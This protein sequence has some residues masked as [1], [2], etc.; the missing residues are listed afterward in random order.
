[1]QLLGGE[2]QLAF[3]F[4]EVLSVEMARRLAWRKGQELPSIRGWCL[5]ATERSRRV[6]FRTRADDQGALISSTGLSLP[7]G[8]WTFY[9]QVKGVDGK[10]GA[11]I[12]ASESIFKSGEVALPDPIP[13]CTIEGRVSP[14]EGAPESVVANLRPEGLG[15]T[16]GGFAFADVDGQG[17]FLLEG[18]P[19]ETQ[20]WIMP[21]EVM[22][23]TGA[24][25]SVVSLP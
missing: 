7:E 2:K 18:L 14:G 17:E 8:D 22:V 13:S 16:R 4:Q 19:P 11:V 20:I 15:A 23:R 10:C 9:G 21:L 3:P 5:S 25:G 24:P 6:S 12:V 1:M